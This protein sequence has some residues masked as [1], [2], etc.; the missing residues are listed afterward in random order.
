MCV[1]VNSNLLYVEREKDLSDL[2]QDREEKTST[3]VLHCPALEEMEGD[4][5]GR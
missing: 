5:L 1:C 2:G 3:E 4:G